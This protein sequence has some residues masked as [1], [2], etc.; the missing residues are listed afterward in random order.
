MLSFSCVFFIVILCCRPCLL[1]SR[2]NASALGRAV[3]AW[4]LCPLSRM[5]LICCALD[6]V[7]ENVRNLYAAMNVSLWRACPYDAT[8]IASNDADEGRSNDTWLD[9][10]RLE[11]R[12]QPRYPL[13]LFLLLLLNLGIPLRPTFLILISTFLLLLLSLLLMLF[14]GCMSRGM[15]WLCLGIRV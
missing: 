1:F 11:P 13:L 2:T 3:A 9:S 5:T 6:V 14:G 8:W 4:P 7:A 15:I 12:L 10:K